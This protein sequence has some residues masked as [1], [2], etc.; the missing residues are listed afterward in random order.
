MTT[1]DITVKGERDK[2]AG[3]DETNPDIVIVR[4]KSGDQIRPIEIPREYINYVKELIDQMQPGERYGSKFVYNR[5]IKHFDIKSEIIKKRLCFISE[6]L[7]EHGIAQNRVQTI[8]DELA[9]DNDFMLMEF[10]ELIGTRDIRTSDYFKIYGCIRYWA[11]K[12]A[13][14]Y[15]QR[16]SIWKR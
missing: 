11:K 10:E 4:Y 2:I 7:S 8:I 13:I 16:G 14:D 3:I 1:E 15:N 5:C 6:K 9:S 12:E